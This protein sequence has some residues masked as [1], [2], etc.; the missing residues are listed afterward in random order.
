MVIAVLMCTVS[1]IFA[2]DDNCQTWHAVLNEK[3]YIS[4]EVSICISTTW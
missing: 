2:S 3:V 1:T 4:V